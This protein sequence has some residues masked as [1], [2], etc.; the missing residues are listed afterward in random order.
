MVIDTHVRPALYEPICKDEVEFGK[1]C[2]AMNYHLMS[3]TPI[4]LLKKQYALA[5]IEK[6]FLLPSDHSAESGFVEIS[7][8]DI[9]TIVNEDPDMFIGFATVDP[10]RI[11]ATEVLT[12]AFHEQKLA[13]LFIDPGRL[14]LSPDDE[15]LMRLYSIC[16]VFKK[17]II[18]QTGMSLEPH[19]YC[20]YSEPMHM[21]RIIDEFGDINICLTHVG[22]PW[23]N[24]VAALLLKYPNAFTDTALMYFDGPYQLYQRVFFKD[25]DKLWVEHNISDKIMFG[26]DMP[27]IRPVRS[28][29][30]LQKLDFS[31]EVMEKIEYTNAQ[32]FLESPGDIDAF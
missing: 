18:L 28:Y 30:A 11:D 29:R 26:S 14:H 20:E 3:P 8:E 24:E 27:R 4:D 1:R 5:N 6:V 31:K 16:E 19:S 21:E 22:W 15:K 7:N 25:M 23:V 17:P 9:C 13:G 10:R 32:R 2:D 12:K